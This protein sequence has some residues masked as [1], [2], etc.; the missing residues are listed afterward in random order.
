[1]ESWGLWREKPQRAVDLSSLLLGGQSGVQLKKQKPWL[2]R[3]NGGKPRNRAAGPRNLRGVARQR[4]RDA[5]PFAEKAA[6]A[7]KRRGRKP[8]LAAGGTK[9]D[10][11]RAD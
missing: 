3:P 7:Q 10:N 5:K 2:E 4:S 1:M 11:V 9:I 6:D 8:G